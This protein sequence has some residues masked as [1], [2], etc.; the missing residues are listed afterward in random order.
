MKRRIIVFLVLTAVNLCPLTA[1]VI[2]KV[3]PGYVLIN[4]DIGLGETG[5]TLWVYRLSGENIYYIGRVKILRFQEGK[6]AAQIIHEAPLLNIQQ[7]DRVL[8]ERIQSGK[9]SQPPSRMQE[10]P[11]Q[12]ASEPVPET[13]GRTEPDFP[14]QPSGPAPA[15]GIRVAR[16]MPR[17]GL[18]GFEDSYLIG[19]SLRLLQA[20]RH[21][22]R[23]E[24]AYPFL[25]LKTPGALDIQ[26]TLITLHLVNHIRMGEQGHYDIGGGL[27]YFHARAVING[28]SITES[29]PF[30]G[31]FFGY[32]IDIPVVNGFAAAPYFR[33]H[34]YQQEIAPG[35]KEWSGFMTGG[36][37]VHIPA[38]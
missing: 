23:V 24:A 1:Q 30:W 31:F 6:T 7:G 18:S 28:E 14:T 9:L 4:T 8:G 38:L 27:Y 29:D 35:T 19:L 17:A 36:V 15:L 5:K 3:V 11:R 21:G 10:T 34:V 13:R 22:L 16:F 32:S 37:T 26:T 25:T 12:P 33:I 2:E 20:G